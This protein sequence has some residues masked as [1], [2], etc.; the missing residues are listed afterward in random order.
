MD[1]DPTKLPNFFTIHPQCEPRYV[2][3]FVTWLVAWAD[4]G[5]RNG[6]ECLHDAGNRMLHWLAKDICSM[7]LKRI[8]S[9][10]IIHGCGDDATD[11]N[12]VLINRKHRLEFLSAC[13]NHQPNR[14]PL[15]RNSPP[16]NTTYIYVENPPY[17]HESSPPQN[18]GRSDRLV[19]Y[20]P[21]HADITCG[22]SLADLHGF[23]L[24]L[25]DGEAIHPLVTEF[26]RHLCDVIRIQER[27]R[28]KPPAEWDDPAWTGFFTALCDESFAIENH[29]S[30]MSCF[31]VSGHWEFHCK[32]LENATLMLTR[33]KLAIRFVVNTDIAKVMWNRI[34]EHDTG[35]A[36]AFE[37]ELEGE[38]QYMPPRDNLFV[39]K[40]RND[41]RQFGGNGQIDLAATIR[42]LQSLASLFAGSILGAYTRCGDGGLENSRPSPCCTI[43][44]ILRFLDPK[45]LPKRPRL[46]RLAVAL[47]D[48]FH[49]DSP[50][51]RPDIHNKFGIVCYRLGCPQ[52]WNGTN[53][54]VEE[55][56]LKPFNMDQVSAQNPMYPRFTDRYYAIEVDTS[57]SYQSSL[58]SYTR[59]QSLV[60]RI[61]PTKDIFAI[62]SRAMRMNCKDKAKRND[63]VS[64]ISNYLI[65]MDLNMGRPVPRKPLGE[66]LDFAMRLL[67]HAHGK[68]KL[69]NDNEH[70]AIK[71][72][73]EESRERMRELF[74]SLHA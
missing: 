35:L 71:L 15:T 32:G 21:D 17:Y 72:A 57:V 52:P 23:K 11:C 63:V 37:Y 39:L 7:T 69:I 13:G 20:D 66:P 45:H 40:Y 18:T 44:W 47:W 2:V 5:L 25:D 60:S 29:P 9:V 70:E 6:H 54:S 38:Y 73:I 53:F 50:V 42:H 55:V 41:Y 26:R 58:V 49:R 62:W 46:H 51:L 34:E 56:I 8:T 74:K 61:N 12:A 48:E 28:T 24:F 43:F 4:P 59:I 31:F 14:N 1:Q 10:E 3:R 27:F 64:E 68:F 33:D 30:E 19:S 65:R 16:E 36:E 22:F 67:K